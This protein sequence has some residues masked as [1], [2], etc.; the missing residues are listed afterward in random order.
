MQRKWL[1]AVATGKPLE[2]EVRS[3]RSDGQYRWQLDRGVPLRD[4]DG[5]IVKWYGVTTDIEDRKR[6]E[7]ALRRN[8][9]YLVRRAAAC[10]YRQLGIYPLPGSSIGLRSCFKST[11]LIRQA[12][13]RRRKNIWPWCIR[14]IGN[15]S[16]K[17]FKRCWRPIGHSTS[18]SESCG[19]TARFEASVAWA[20]PRLRRG[21]SGDSWARGWMSLSKSN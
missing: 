20:F 19:L 12:S 18:R 5:N 17:R 13:R 16:S 21:L 8:E 4:E 7:E 1:E 9:F 3:R 6:V 2:N 14:K 11:D 15:S 10:P